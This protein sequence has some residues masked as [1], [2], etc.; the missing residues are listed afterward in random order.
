ML[1]TLLRPPRPPVWL[2]QFL[3]RAAL[4]EGESALFLDDSG[5][6]FYVSQNTTR[7]K[8]W[9]EGRLRRLSALI[10]LSDTIPINVDFDPK[11]HGLKYSSARGQ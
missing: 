8:T 10:A 5:Y 11:I 9:V 1:R 4:G 3:I 2:E 7:E 6:T